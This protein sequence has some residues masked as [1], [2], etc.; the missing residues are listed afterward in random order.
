[1]PKLSSTLFPELPSSTASRGYSKPQVSGN[2]S[3]KNILG[4][5]TGAVVSAWQPPSSTGEPNDVVTVEEQG[6]DAHVPVGV[7]ATVPTKGKKGKGKQKQTLFTLGSF[8]T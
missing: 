4:N 1:M 7:P 3:L 5:T 8:P 2:V 6:D